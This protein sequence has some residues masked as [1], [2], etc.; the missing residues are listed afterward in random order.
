MRAYALWFVAVLL[1]ALCAFAYISVEERS[2]VQRTANESAESSDE[3]PIASLG[4]ANA[5]LN[6]QPLSAADFRGKVVLVDFWTYTCINWRRTLPYLRAWS[7]KYADQG[8]IVVGVHTPE[9]SFERDAGNVARVASAQKVDYPIA[10]DSDYAIWNG[11]SN[12]YWPAVYVIDAQGRI[13]HQQFG[14]ANYEQLEGVVQKLLAE[15]GHKDFDPALISGEGQGAE[16]AADWPNPR[17]PETYVLI[18]T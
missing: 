4:R 12:R 2:M 6:S 13:R 11:F 7:Q 5:W 18:G 9:F 15:A 1:S 14:E 8:L 16:L 17:T 3:G 10:I